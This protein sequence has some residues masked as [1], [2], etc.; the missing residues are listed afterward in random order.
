[1]MHFDSECIA[2]EYIQ[3]YAKLGRRG[4]IATVKNIHRRPNE[5][6]Q[7]MLSTICH[8]TSFNNDKRPEMYGQRT[9]I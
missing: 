9:Q 3:F 5:S 8:P 1:M 6:D 2:S 7:Q 4:M